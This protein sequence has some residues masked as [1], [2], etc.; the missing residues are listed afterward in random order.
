MAGA[1]PDNI[2]PL[3]MPGME[4]KPTAKSE[5]VM[6][7]RAVLKAMLRLVDSFVDEPVRY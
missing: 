6:G 5:L 1:I 3:I 7:I 4:T 2:C